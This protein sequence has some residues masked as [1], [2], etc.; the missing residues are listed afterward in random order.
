[1]SRLNLVYDLGRYLLHL[2]RAIIAAVLVCHQQYMVE[3]R[4][5]RV[6]GWGFRE[7]G[8]VF[9]RRG[10]RG[11]TAWD[12]RDREEVR[13]CGEGNSMRA[14]PSLANVWEE[15]GG[16]RVVEF[17]AWGSMDCISC[18]DTSALGQPCV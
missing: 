4:D 6:G 7:V 13:G 9:V 2:S 8:G 14:I 17:G 16:C 10:G 3:R 1:M 12:V 5:F 15:L 11:D 18:D